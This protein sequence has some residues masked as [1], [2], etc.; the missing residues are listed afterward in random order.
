MAHKTSA[1]SR[2]CIGEA[3][4]AVICRANSQTSDAESWEGEGSSTPSAQMM[5]QASVEAACEMSHVETTNWTN[6]CEAGVIVLEHSGHADEGGSSRS[7]VFVKHNEDNNTI[8][9]Q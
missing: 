3:F 5:A 9:Q 8:R 2:S 7:N 4:L 1:Q 6:T